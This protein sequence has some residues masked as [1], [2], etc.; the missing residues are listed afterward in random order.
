MFDSLLDTG[1]SDNFVD[2]KAAESLG[3]KPRGGTLVVSMASGKLNAPI[4]GQISG[5]LEIQGRNYFDVTLSVVPDLCSDIVLGQSFKNKHKEI[6]FKLNGAQEGL[7]IQNPVRCGVATS[8]VKSPRLFN[9]LDPNAK[10]IAGK[11]RRF[12]EADQSF[13]KEEVK[14]LLAEGNIEPSY[15]PWRAQVLATKDERHKRRMV[16]DYSQTVNRYTLLDVYPLPNIDEQVA[17]IAKCSVFSTLDLKSAYYQASLSVKDRPYT[18]FEAEGKLY[19]YTRLPFAVTNVV[20][21]FQRVIDNIIAKYDLRDTYAYLDNITVCGK[22]MKD[23]DHNLKALF[24]AAKSENLTFNNS[25]CVFVRTEIDLLGYRISHNLIQWFSTGD[26]IA[27]G[28]MFS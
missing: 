13:I 6:T 11:S 4:L 15:S 7:V 26:D 12:N 18:A 23:H 27:P 20:S 21:F 10:P 24:S 25:K 8:N 19:Q 16:V 14:Q 28:R 5:N 9:N 2:K 22:T 3:L 17:K 1:A